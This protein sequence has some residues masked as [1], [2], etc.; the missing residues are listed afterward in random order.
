[1]KKVTLFGASGNLGRHI[2]RQL[3]QHGYELTVVL[4]DQSKAKLFEGLGLNVVIAD[5]CNKTSL[6]NT[7]TGQEVVVSTLG[8]S[9]SPM[10]NSKPSF[11]QVDYEGNLNI[12][13]EAKR[14]GV[15]KFVYISAF[16]SENYPQLEYFKVHHD[17][18]EALKSSGI[19]YSIIK[20]PAL[21]SAFIDLI[22]M[23]K[24]RRLINI[25]RGD[26][27]T[28]PIYEGDL[29][30]IAVD[31]IKLS[32]A[33]IEAG[34]KNIYTRRQLYEIIQ[35]NVNGHKRLI[36][37]QTWL[38]KLFFPLIKL[39]NKNQYDKVAFFC[40]VMQHDTIAPQVGEM[41]FEEYVRDQLKT[42]P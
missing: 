20:P 11:R 4:R 2:A 40:E 24:K 3:V 10:E 27:K 5:P 16:H 39:T 26:K 36:T 1:M 35:Q 12:L 8:K 30:M 42:L 23:A 33:V 22:E 13:N 34:G 25:G 9:V 21:F 17:F 7:L 15:R 28:N 6:E 38:L 19:D 14:A 31:S 37:I 32:N 18:S 29:A 41:G